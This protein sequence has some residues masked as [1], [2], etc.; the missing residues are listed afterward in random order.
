M[1]TFYLHRHGHNTH[2]TSLRMVIETS[3]KRRHQAACEELGKLIRDRKD[4]PIN[5]NHYYTDTVHKKR[6]ER[7]QAQILEHIS[8]GSPQTLTS[9]SKMNDR[10]ENLVRHWADKATPNMEECS[11]EEALD[12]L[13]AI[14]KV[15]Q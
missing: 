8:K 4:F 3:L 10:V 9:S 15:R 1:D 6:Q 5:Y 7:I 12:C 13:L 11:C 2:G 14:Y